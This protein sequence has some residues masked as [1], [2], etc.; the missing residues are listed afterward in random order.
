MPHCR[1]APHF[2]RKDIQA[3]LSSVVG[4]II[5]LPYVLSEDLLQVYV[6]FLPSTVNRFMAEG[7]LEKRIAELEVKNARLKDRVGEYWELLKGR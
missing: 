2:S 1:R 5:E 7:D 3:A 6:R 4:L